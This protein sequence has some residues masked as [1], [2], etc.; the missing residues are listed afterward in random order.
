MCSVKNL[1]QFNRA[2]LIPHPSNFDG[3]LQQTFPF[4]LSRLRVSEIL[5]KTVSAD[6]KVCFGHCEKKIVAA[7]RL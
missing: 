4:P 3:P 7:S 6:A 5:S 1:P 2:K